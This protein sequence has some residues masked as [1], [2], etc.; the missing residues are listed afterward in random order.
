LPCSSCASL[1]IKKMDTTAHTFSPNYCFCGILK[2]A[3]SHVPLAKSPPP[4]PS[5]RRTAGP[6]RAAGAAWFLW[7]VSLRGPEAVASQRQGGTGELCL[8]TRWPE[9]SPAVEGRRNEVGRKKSRSP[10]RGELF[11]GGGCYCCNVCLC[12]LSGS[13]ELCK[14]FPT[15]SFSSPPNP[16]TS[17]KNRNKTKQK[18]KNKTKQ[19]KKNQNHKPN[20]NTCLPE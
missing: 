8:W 10:R 1:K 12:F 13:P 17:D 15:F 7:P 5:A 3:F 18:N 16:G 14:R 20:Q 2:F 11:G 4:Y 9:P 6:G 19:K